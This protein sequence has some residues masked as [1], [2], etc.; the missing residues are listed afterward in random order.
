[1][2]RVPLR[3]GNY[4]LKNIVYPLITAA[5]CILLFADPILA[6]NVSESLAGSKNT[7]VVLSIFPLINAFLLLE[8]VYRLLRNACCPLRNALA[9]WE[10]PL[11]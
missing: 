7:V 5:V 6:Q 10:M 2:V 9:P 4:G 11:S 8:N 3:P 1:M